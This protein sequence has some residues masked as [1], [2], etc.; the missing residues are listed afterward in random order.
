[1]FDGLAEA[2]IIIFIITIIALVIS[3]AV[4]IS[5]RWILFKKCGEEGW[6]SLIPVYT[7][8][9]VLKV[10]GLSWWW[11]FLIYGYSIFYGL[12]LFFTFYETSTMSYNYETATTILS[13]IN[14]FG[15]LI[16]L[17]AKFNIGLNLSKKFNQSAGYGVLIMFFEPI[18]FYILGLSKSYE[19]DESVEVSKNGVFGFKKENEVNVFCPE[20][21]TQGR[22][23]DIYCNNCGKKMR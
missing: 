13:L 23:S 1:M 22:S 10:S 4:K 20:C 21:G 17:F 15:S 8:L 18:M 7:D 6:K 14:G 9:T 5:S 12:N 16:Y 11:I 19:Y 2:L 3:L